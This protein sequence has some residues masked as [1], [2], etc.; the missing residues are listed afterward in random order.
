MPDQHF[1]WARFLVDRVWNLP[2]R[3]VAAVSLV[4]ELSWKSWFLLAA[5]KQRLLTRSWLWHLKNK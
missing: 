1:R 5:A 3:A 4:L 2:N